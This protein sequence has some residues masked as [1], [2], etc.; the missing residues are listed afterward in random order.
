[1]AADGLGLLPVT[2][3]FSREKTTVR[4]RARVAAS[5]PFAGAAGSE[6]A[7]YE[8]HAGLSEAPRRARAPFTI[9]ARGGIS[10]SD[11]EG[12]VNGRGN[13]VGTYLHGL[14]ASGPLRRSLLC[15]LAELRGRSAD[16]R[17][18]L[19]GADRY[20]RLADIV[21]GALDMLAIAKLAGLPLP[22]P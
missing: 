9:V 17:W 8:I 20:E 7:A 2:T 13:V 16:P 18:G 19:P 1:V 21:G 12:A 14:F 22:R 6:L 15:F 3:T 4:V 10:A 11:P 5:G